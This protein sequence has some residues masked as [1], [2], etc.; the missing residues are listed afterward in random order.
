M[1]LD[2]KIEFILLS[3]AAVCPDVSYFN[4]VKHQEILRMILALN[5]LYL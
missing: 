2:N 4:A 1:T 3:M 5:E